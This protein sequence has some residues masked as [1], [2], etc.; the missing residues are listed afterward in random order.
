MSC[1]PRG[2]TIPARAH[3]RDFLKDSDETVRQT[4]IHTASLWREPRAALVSSRSVLSAPNRRARPGAGA[5]RRE[6]PCPRRWKPPHELTIGSEHS[7]TYALIEI[8]DPQ[9]TAAGLQAKDARVTRSAMVALDQMEGGGLDPK[10]AAGLLA[11]PEPALRETA[12]WI[13]GRHSE[14]AD[15]LAGVLG[16]RLDRADLPAA[17]RAELERQLGRFAQAANPAAPGRAVAEHLTHRAARAVCR[18]WPGR[19]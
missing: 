10:F 15:A 18:P 7:I 9:G 11:S 16:E 5:D 17:E 12:S 1:G 19:T 8:A 4:A 14:W 2:S 6:A 13:V 3:V